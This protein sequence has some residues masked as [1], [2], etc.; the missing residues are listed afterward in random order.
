MSMEM[1]SLTTWNYVLDYEPYLKQ[2][3]SNWARFVSEHAN[4]WIWHFQTET[5]F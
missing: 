3:F 2:K 1:N 5:L 4:T